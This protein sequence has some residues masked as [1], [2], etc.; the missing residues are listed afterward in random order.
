MPEEIFG[1]RQWQCEVQSNDN[2]ATF[3]KELVLKLPEGE[4]VDFRA[5]GYVQLE[6][7]PHSVKYSDFEI[8][9]EYRSDWERF[10]FFRLESS[11]PDT[12][13]RAYSMANYPEE[14]GIVKF[15]IRVAAPPPGSGDQVPPGIMSSWA[16]NL[17]AGDL[18]NVYGPFELIEQV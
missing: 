3:I 13:I 10:N 8:S 1:V 17:K 9:D 11:C 5:G 7:P 18:V 4:S 6:C 15:N 16:F 2:V 14:K 12:T